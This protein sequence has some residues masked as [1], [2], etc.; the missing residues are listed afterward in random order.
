LPT[1]GALC[2]GRKN[3]AVGKGVKKKKKK[4]AKIRPVGSGHM[5]D[6]TG[7]DWVASPSYKR[8]LK[9]MVNRLSVAKRQYKGCV[10]G[11]TPKHKAGG[12]FRKKNCSRVNAI[13][14]GKTLRGDREAVWKTS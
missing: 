11:E 7:R 4:V 8:E 14:K 2:R 5:R 3:S 13:H 9:D 1:N 10:Q 6:G 12:G